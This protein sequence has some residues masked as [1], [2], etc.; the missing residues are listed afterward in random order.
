MITVSKNVENGHWVSYKMYNLCGGQFSNWQIL[1]SITL[2]PLPG[3]FLQIHK[4]SCMQM[5]ATVYF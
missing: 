2:R 3:A 5:S 1:N 4:L